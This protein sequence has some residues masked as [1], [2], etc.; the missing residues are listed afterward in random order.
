MQD[1]FSKQDIAGLL[2]N[3]ESIFLYQLP[4]SNSH[5]RL[6]QLNADV[7]M[8]GYLKQKLASE[9][10]RKTILTRRRIY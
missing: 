10:P 1:E 4:N 9:K 2:F 6:K 7:E 8:L 3:K 5:C